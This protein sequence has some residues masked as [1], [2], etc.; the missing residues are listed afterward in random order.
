MKEAAPKRVSYPEPATRSF[1]GSPYENW[2]RARRVPKVLVRSRGQGYASIIWDA[3]PLENRIHNGW[4]D[5]ADRA[6]LTELIS[7]TMGQ[8]YAVVGGLFMGYVDV[9]DCSF[10]QLTALAE[11][12]AAFLDGRFGVQ[13][14]AA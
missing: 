3:L 2:C 8:D 5:E 12:I 13:H 10:S 14:A 7:T 6:D 11:R 9:S 4:P 1:H